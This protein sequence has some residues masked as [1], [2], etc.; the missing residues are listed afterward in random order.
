MQP[1]IISPVPIIT[2]DNGQVT[3][4]AVYHSEYGAPLE[5]A[6]IGVATSNTTIAAETTILGETITGVALLQD[7]TQADASWEL[8]DDLTIVA[9]T[10]EQSRWSE[11]RYTAQ[12]CGNPTVTVTSG[13]TSIPSFPTEITWSYED[14]AGFFQNKI[15]LKL[16]TSLMGNVVISEYTSRHSISVSGDEIAFAAAIGGTETSISAELTVWSTSG[17]S[18]TTD[19]TLTVQPNSLA[20]TFDASANDG[21]MLIEGT[22]SFFLFC[23]A[24]N[25][26]KQCAYTESGTLD[27]RLPINNARYFAI[28]LNDKRIGRAN[29]ITSPIA[30]NCGY[31]DY[32]DN[33]VLSRLD[34]LLDG[35]EN[36]SLDNSVEFSHFAGRKNPVAYFRETE[37]TLT[38]RCA[39]FGRDLDKLA[40][41]LRGKEG[42]YRS[43]RD[44]IFRVAIESFEYDLYRGRAGGGEISLKMA[45]VD[46]DPYA[47]FYDSPFFIDAQLYP[48]ADTYPSST[49]WTVG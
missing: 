23:L 25:E 45:V 42:V 17:L 21:N 44:G 19:L 27:F 38:A 26:C 40:E 46:G 30:I 8:G 16:H 11:T 28:T 32:D 3:I 7:I 18:N 1:S 13:G 36:H 49:T 48:G 37:K 20:F 34:N 29:E 33:G 15:E 5:D 31:L 12:T 35:E 9:R 2:F 4:T 41:S 43:V 47:M 24:N 6:Q 10:K 22:S 14:Y 39:L